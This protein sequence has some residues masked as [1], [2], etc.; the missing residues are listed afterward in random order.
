[1]SDVTNSFHPIQTSPNDEGGREE[2]PGVRAP[3]F[4][5]SSESTLIVGTGFRKASPMRSTVI[6]EGPTT[7]LDIVLKAALRSVRDEAVVK[8]SLAFKMW[9][10][11]SKAKLATLMILAS[12]R[13]AKDHLLSELLEKR[14]QMSGR[15]SEGKILSL[16]RIRENEIVISYFFPDGGATL[17]DIAELTGFA[18]STVK[19]CLDELIEEGLVEREGKRKGAKFYIKEDILRI[20]VGQKSDTVGFVDLSIPIALYQESIVA[21]LAKRF[22]RR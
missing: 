1:M 15:G 13:A 4:F 10:E 9:R 22:I 2:V 18:A 17:T 6:D 12:I 20:L 21:E 3:N 14:Y 8:N 19:T 16:P 5:N 11:M 7:N